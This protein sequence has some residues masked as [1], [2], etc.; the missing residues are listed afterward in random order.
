MF[1]AF[2]SHPHVSSYPFQ[3]GNNQI[4]KMEMGR[5]VGNQ[6]SVSQHHRQPFRPISNQLHSLGRSM[7]FKGL[8]I[9]PAVLLAFSRLTNRTMDHEVDNCHE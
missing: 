9:I 6:L 8:I 7:L 3:K 1:P 2:H 4:I 5:V